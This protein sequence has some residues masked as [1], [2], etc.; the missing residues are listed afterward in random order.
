V[1]F[2]L[3][4]G[5]A[6]RV[7]EG[8]P[9]PAAIRSVS[10]REIPKPSSENPA[11]S[12]DL[13]AVVGMA[14]AL[15]PGSRYATV[16]EFADDL[17]RLIAGEPV[18]ARPPGSWRKLRSWMRREPRLAG[19]VGVAVAATL[20]L[21]VSLAI[22]AKATGEEA[23]R[24]SEISR[25]VYDQLVPAAAK[26][27]VTQDAPYIRE[28]DEAAYQLSLLVN[29]PEHEV[30]AKLALKLAFDWLKGVGYDPAESERWAKVA[31]AASAAVPSLGPNSAT[32][33]EARCVEAWALARRASDARS[34]GEEFALLA[35]QKLVDLL[36][37]VEGRDDVDLASDCL[38]TL[39]EYAE[40]SGDLAQAIG[41]Y[42]RAI[43]RSSRIRGE[44]DEMVIQTRSYLVDTLRRQERF[45][46]VLA[47]LDAILSIQREH[48]RGFSPWTIRFAMQRGEA[49]LRLGRYKEAEI[50]LAE[51][52]V[53]VR[54]RIGPNHG[55]RNRIRNYM[56]Q[57]LVAL[58]RSDEAEREWKDVE[59][60]G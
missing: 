12:G 50:Q 7:F 14:C 11:I 59:L 58:G 38:G 20:G 51:A 26:L 28:I 54:D 31:H 32:S 36:P 46:E 8:V 1:L 10:E 30:T 52:D 60:A 44:F 24:A 55:M 9:L 39:G 21:V 42:Q 15:E 23:R 16:Q 33:I 43:T 3:V 25:H 27:G 18:R 13:D 5:K 56:R 17:A 53:L 49:L 41:Y 22:Y 35:R 48:E 34:G 45:P 6:P 57:A 37:V 40:R 19:A 4:T 47:E 29:G 2:E